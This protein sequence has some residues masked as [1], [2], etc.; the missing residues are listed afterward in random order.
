MEKREKISG[1]IIPDIQANPPPVQIEAISLCPITSYL[2]KE[3]D[4]L[5]TVT[6]LQVVV[7]EVS[8]P[9]SFSSD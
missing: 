5:L 2:R 7:D 4:A 8:T 6:F 1:K 3:M 9:A